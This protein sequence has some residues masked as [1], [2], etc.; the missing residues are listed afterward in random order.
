MEIK[1]GDYGILVSD[2]THEILVDRSIDLT[3]TQARELET[4]NDKLDTEIDYAQSHVFQGRDEEA[5]VIIRIVK[6]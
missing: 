3:V 1:I 5:F 4:G 2:K 6:D